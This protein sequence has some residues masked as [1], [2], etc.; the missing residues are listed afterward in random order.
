MQ[1][2]IP[3]PEANWAKGAT[4]FDFLTVKP[5]TLPLCWFKFGGP[6]DKNSKTLSLVR[7]ICSNSNL[8]DCPIHE[9]RASSVA[10][11]SVETVTRH[12]EGDHAY[13]YTCRW[14]DA[15]KNG[16][17][18][19]S[20]LTPLTR[21]KWW[22]TIMSSTF[23]E[24]IVAAV[25]ESRNSSFYRCKNFRFYKIPRSIIQL[26]YSYKLLFEENLNN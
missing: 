23:A 18:A 21:I 11:G 24:S 5:M 6:K 9:Q 17:P 10:S 3:N 4:R 13:V 7:R 1:G 2:S 26:C 14:K 19:L 12:A 22:S 20:P 16:Q 15:R 25:L 8:H